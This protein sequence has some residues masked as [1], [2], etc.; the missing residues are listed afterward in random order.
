MTGPDLQPVRP[1]REVAQASVQGAR[2][3]L[4][5]AGL[6]HRALEQVRPSDITDKQEVAGR[7]ADRVGGVGRV[8]HEKRQVLRRMARRV[9]HVDA[10]SADVDR[11]AVGE[12]LDAAVIRKGVAPL[13]AAFIRHV[14]R[15]ARARRELAAAG[16][17]I[18][19][20]VRFG[21]VRNARMLRLGC[22]DVLLRVAIWIDHDRFTG[23]GAADEIT[24][25]RELQLEETL[26]EHR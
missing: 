6:M 2:A 24:R 7:R 10:D 4:H 8:R 9:E 12:A 17:E 19:V 5:R 21:D 26:Q 15:C 1:R 11:R 16:H 20:D 25:L 23:I 18:R 3:L 13:I 22:L 14:Q